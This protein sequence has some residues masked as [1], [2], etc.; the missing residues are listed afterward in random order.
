MWRAGRA[1]GTECLHHMPAPGSACRI[2]ISVE[3]NRRRRAG[4]RR[5]SRGEAGRARAREHSCAHDSEKQPLWPCTARQGKGSLATKP[6]SQ[7]IALVPVLL[8]S[9]WQ[10]LASSSSAT[11]PKARDGANVRIARS[12][13]CQRFLRRPRRAIFP[14]ETGSSRQTGSQLFRAPRPPAVPSSR[15]RALQLRG[16]PS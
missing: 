14:E 12:R 13:D 1:R 4:V 16:L 6:A 7:P 9:R 11:W 8:P 10:R 2:L 15:A 3:G 5:G